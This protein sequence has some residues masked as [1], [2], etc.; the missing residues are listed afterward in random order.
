MEGFA[1]KTHCQNLRKHPLPDIRDLARRFAYEPHTGKFFTVRGEVGCVGNRG[2]VQISYSYAA[3]HLLAHRVAFA[4]MRGRWPHQ[5]DHINGDK[6]DNRW[7]NLREVTN[8]QN[9]KSKR[10]LS[11]VASAIRAHQG[12]FRVRYCARGERAS[13]RFTLWR[14]AYEF[15]LAYRRGLARDLDYV[16]TVPPKLERIK[17]L[18]RSTKRKGDHYDRP[19][20]V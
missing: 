18:M 14:D 2:Y 12:V 19:F 20:S 3:A 15:E 11:T 9:T 13:L 17:P 6:A 10:C 8:G 7:C 1:M 4:L 16:P 5:I